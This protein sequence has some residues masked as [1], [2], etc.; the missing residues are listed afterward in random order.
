VE[1]F[2]DGQALLTWLASGV[3]PLADVLLLDLHLPGTDGLTLLPQLRQQWPALRVLVF[4]NAAAPELVDRLAA[5]GASGFVSKSADAEQLLAAIRAVGA[6]GTA[7]PKHVRT[8]LAQASTEKT[9]PLLRL[10]RLSTRERQVTSL[11]RQGLTTREIAE[12]LCLAEFTI[13]THRRNIMHKLE[14]GNVA[15]LVQFAIDYGL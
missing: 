12:R 3:L 8:V 14:L 2:A 10:H 1:Q 5:A 6:G 4:S 13:S 7:F 15:A 9:D 11:V